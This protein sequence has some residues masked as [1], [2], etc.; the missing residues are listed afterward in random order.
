MY[1][2]MDEEMEE[3]V[4]D[5]FEFSEVDAEYEFD[6]A[7]FFDFTRPESFSEAEEAE[8]W[9]KSARSYPPSPFIIKLKWR[10]DIMMENANACLKSNDDG[11]MDSS[12]N[13]LDCDMDTEVMVLDDNSKGLKSHNNTDQDILQ[14]KTK[15]VEKS[16]FI[17]SSTLMKPTAS[18]LA[19]LNGAKEVS[20]RCFRRSQ[21]PLHKID[22]R[23][24]TNPLGI[25][26]DATKR[27]KLEN[28]YLR[29]VAQLKHQSLLLH[30]LPKVRQVD[31]NTMN[32]RS[33]VTIPREPHLE[34][35][36]RAQ[37][38]R[39]RINSESSE[40]AKPK[41]PTF[42]ARPLNRKV[43]KA[44]SLPPQKK[45]KPQSPDFQVS[46]L[47]T[48]ERTMQHSSTNE[49]D[50]QNSESISKTVT[51]NT[52]KLSGEDAHKQKKCAAIRRVKA[53]PFCK[54]DCKLPND[55]VLS[56]IPPVELF[57]KLSINSELKHNL[58]SPTKLRHHAK[59]PKE[60]VP[61][62]FKQELRRHGSKQ[63]QCGSE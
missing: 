57:N 47:K 45:S 51:N 13:N 34:T 58:R 61:S 32:S 55:N 3:F 11:C 2:D 14:T 28:G 10:E 41:A 24:L 33:K 39:S 18:H 26:G 40:H 49:L 30:K 27:Q 59:G 43:F 15:F 31:A 8:R 4:A 21:K 38:H 19:K 6:A 35:A 20:S 60:N 1:G 17:R 5:F 9:F 36:H 23:R 29:K 22:E 25:D 48:S 52:E 62:S 46:H 42:K 16:S 63:N 56:Y 44:A 53:R 7:R 12:S 54:K 37:R 50:M